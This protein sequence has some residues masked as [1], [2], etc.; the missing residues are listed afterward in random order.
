MKYS[1]LNL[2]QI[3]AVVNKLGGM[4]GVK[5]LLA[6][7]TIIQTIKRKFDIWKTINLGTHKSADDFRKALK[8]SGNK[9]YDW[10]DDILGTSDFNKRI[11]Q[12]EKEIDLVIVTVEELGFKD[13]ATRKEIYDRAIEL[14]LKLCPAEVGPQLRLQYED[15]PNGEYLHI[16]M[17]PITDSGGDLG[18]FGVEH[19]DGGRWLDAYYGPP[20]DVWRSDGRWVFVHSK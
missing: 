17:E 3:E 5:A 11:A 10:A 9:I 16:S 2:G 1:Q 15:Q 20:D 13:S 14:G 18:V 7:E 19:G 8:K 4:D 6:G 12:T